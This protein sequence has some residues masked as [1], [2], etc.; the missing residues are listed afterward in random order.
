[1]E[2]LGCRMCEYLT[3]QDDAQLFSNLASLSGYIASSAHTALDSLACL[4]PLRQP[5]KCSPTVVP[6]GTGRSPCRDA[7]AASRRAGSSQP[8]G[9]SSIGGGSS[10]TTFPKIAA[11]PVTPL[12]TRWRVGLSALRSYPVY[13]YQPETFLEWAPSL[14]CSHRIPSTWK[15]NGCKYLLHEH[16]TSE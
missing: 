2:L 15:V 4:L 10:L 3:L 11:H 16:R 14:S 6:F 13:C 7:H 1:M 9:H 8:G 12:G 5:A